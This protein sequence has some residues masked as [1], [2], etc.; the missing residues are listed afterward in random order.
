M[1]P[2]YVKL[3]EGYIGAWYKRIMA[4][5]MER[6]C[7]PLRPTESREYQSHAN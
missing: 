2:G 6:S 7:D 4:D 1:P 3:L 5:L